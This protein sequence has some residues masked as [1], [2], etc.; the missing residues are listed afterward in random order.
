[1]LH[2]SF[3]QVFVTNTPVLLPEGQTVDAIA[4]GQ[5]GVLDGK[6]YVATTAP[7][8]GKNKAL[9][10]VWGQPDLPQS[11]LGGPNQNEYSKLIKGKL[12]RNFRGQKASRGQNQVVTVGFSGDVSDTDT[13]SAKPGQLYELFLNLTGEAI[14]KEYS[15]QGIQRRYYYRKDIVDDCVDT[16][17]DVDPREVAQFFAKQING[18]KTI[19]RYVKALINED[20]TPDV[21]AGTTRTLYNFKLTTADSKDY[22]ALGLVQAQYPGLGVKRIG[23]DGINSVYSVTRDANTTPAAFSNAGT[24]VIPDCDTCPTGYTLINT[25]FAYKVVRNDAGND[26]AKTAIATEFGIDGTERVARTAYEFGQSTYTVVS[27]TE[28]ADAAGLESLGE[29]RQSCVLTTPTTIAWVADGTLLQAAKTYRV[30][31]ADDIC[32]NDRLADVQ[33]AY[34]DNVVTLVDAAGDCVHSYDMVVYSNPYE[35]G[36]GIEQA[37]FNAPTSFEG[38]EWRALPDAPL[39]NGTVCKT[40][41]RLEVGVV[42][43]VTNEVTF[44]SFPYDASAVYLEVSSGNQDYNSNIP[45][46]NLWAVKYIQNVKFPKGAGA[47]IQKLEQDSLAY[48]RKVRSQDAYIRQLEAYE[49]QAKQG[50]FYDEYVLEFDFEYMVGGWS[51]R[52]TDSY[53]VFVYVPEGQ[54][55]AF[56]TAINSYLASSNINIEPVIL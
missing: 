28:L 25:G 2:Q 36:C 27:D 11:I 29:V 19:N 49:F 56:E 38:A 37:T 5:V 33:A 21:P 7:T 32:G 41:L 12:I 46:E 4:V 40:G 47:Y 9:Y 24:L 18:D 8:Y 6:S 50:L 54:G 52:Y 22:Y 15:A 45:L 10:L 1:M 14:T 48:N 31:L 35:V 17:V 34:P 20:C 13:M 44:D 43:P 30:T 23:E 16:C 51:Q 55:K 53:S 26:A 42:H 3:R 39:A